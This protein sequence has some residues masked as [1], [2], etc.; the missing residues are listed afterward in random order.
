MFFLTV[1]L[2]TDPRG[3]PLDPHDLLWAACKAPEKFAMDIGLW[4]IQGGLK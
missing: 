2:G 4:H 3:D 1:F